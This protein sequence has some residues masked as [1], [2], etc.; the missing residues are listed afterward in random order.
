MCSFV[1]P[2]SSCDM[3]LDDFFFVTSPDVDSL[4]LLGVELALFTFFFALHDWVS[5]K[6]SSNSVIVCNT[7]NL[8]FLIQTNVLLLLYFIL[9]PYHILLIL[10]T[11][12]L[13]VSHF[14]DDVL[15][16]FNGIINAH[17]VDHLV[18]DECYLVHTIL[19]H[20]FIHR[21]IRLCEKKSSPE[22]LSLNTNVLVVLDLMKQGVSHFLRITSYFHQHIASLVNH[23]LLCTACYH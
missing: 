13:K 10:P 23:T 12:F 14:L 17:L 6:L 9:L 21:C 20:R 16:L 7:M 11:V 22:F 2:F 4:N 19:F 3:L 18:Q 15:I 5:D 8:L 1:E